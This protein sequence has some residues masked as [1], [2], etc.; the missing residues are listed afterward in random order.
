MGGLG[1][2]LFQVFTI[3]ALAIRTKRLFTFPDKK[4]DG[5]KR[6][7]IYWDTLLKE[8]KKNTFNFSIDKLR[9]P[10]YKETTFHYNDEMERHP[11][12][13]NPLNGIVLFGYFQSYKYF[14]KETSKII[15][16]LKINEQ[17]H[18]MKKLLTSISQNK[19][20]I[21]LHF[22]LGDYKS[23]TQ[24]YTPIGVDYYINSILYIL[25][26]L[27]KPTPESIP[28]ES[29]SSKYIVLYFCEDNDFAEVE[30]NI[31]LLH[32]RFPSI[33]F[34]R[35]PNNIEDWQSMLLMSCCDHNI[36]ANS[37][38]SWWSAYLNTNPNKIVCYP[39]KWF[40]PGLPSHTTNDLCPPSWS[41]IKWNSQE[42]IHNSTCV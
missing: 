30:I 6:Q 32:K 3:I 26:S 19:E 12:I 18:D 11:C 33:I 2:Q 15:N 38:F 40:G 39:D 16:Y 37:T 27:D 36:I 31:D 20:T 1:N 34:K 25:T 17:K 35:A 22:R 9:L 5:D 10:M 14:D 13:K 41:K 21:S 42:E 4:L 8:L 7:N 28:P 23:L 29:I 24:H